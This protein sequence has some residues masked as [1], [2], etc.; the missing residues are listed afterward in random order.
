MRNVIGRSAALALACVLGF[1]LSPG[2]AND[3]APRDA[4]EGTTSETGAPGTTYYVSTEGSDSNPGTLEAPW[5]SPGYGS[6]QLEAGDTMV[7]LGGRYTLETYWDDT[8]TPPG[9]SAGAPTTIRGGEGSRPVL[10]G[11]GDLFSAVDVSGLSYVRI[12]NLEIT[13]DNGA[14]F[15]EGIN[16][17]DGPVEHLVL[18][19]LYI[20]HIDEAA[21]DLGDVYDLQVL[22]CT[23]THCGFGCLMGPE[24]EEGG[25][26]E[27]LIEGCDLSYSGH[28]YQG[29]PGPGPYDRPDGLGIEPSQGPV[30]IR[31]TLCE[32]N[33]GDGL[34][35]KAANTYI[36]ECVVANNACDG[37]KLWQ[38]PSRV[39]NTLVY[40]TGDGTG[41]ASPWAGL[42]VDS[43]APGDVFEFVN[44]TVH[45]DPSR[46]AYP[47]YFQYEAA[48][49]VEILMRNCIV[50]GGHGPVYFGDSVDLICEHSI[51]YRP[52]EDVQIYAEGRDYTA[53][54]LEAGAVG[55]GNISRDPMFVSPAWGEQGDYRLQAGS[56][57]IDAGSAEDAP[58][59]DLDGVARPQG[60]GFDMGAYEYGSGR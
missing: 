5:A 21:V 10:A 30:E 11:S 41:G 15:R 36:H 40:G 8:I 51:L 4:E 18:E 29:G 44:V 25:W 24:G 13:S 32:H 19:D 31:N 52:G 2:C 48:A 49:P 9:G 12:E 53:A 6:K 42:V 20:H 37:I 59:F 34:D 33:R 47:A 38:G 55:E 7:I 54:E 60:G 22:N 43:E 57:A 27:V 56:P 58:T 3:A 26:R 45:D 39:E 23:M 28:Y 16:G 14:D 1:C 46:E 17:T 35:S 50:A